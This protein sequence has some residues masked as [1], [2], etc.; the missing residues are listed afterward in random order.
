MTAWLLAGMLLANGGYSPNGMP[1]EDEEFEKA[2]NTCAL[3]VFGQQLRDSS[4]E[5]SEH[6]AKYDEAVE[7]C[8]RAIGRLLEH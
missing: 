5:P 2:V 8:R 3:M 4:I 6:G 7:R 1:P